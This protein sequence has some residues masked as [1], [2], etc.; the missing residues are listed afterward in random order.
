MTGQSNF[1]EGGVFEA[2]ASQS[3]ARAEAVLPS[4]GSEDVSHLL[5]AFTAEE[6]SRPAFDEDKDYLPNRKVDWVVH[7]DFPPTVVLRKA[8]IASI[9]NQ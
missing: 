8:N 7:V 3:K 6:L 4:Q 1:G 9:F 2:T 5:R